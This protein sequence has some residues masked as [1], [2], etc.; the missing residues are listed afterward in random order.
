MLEDIG[1][2]CKEFWEENLVTSKFLDR[3]LLMCEDNV[4]SSRYS[5]TQSMQLLSIQKNVTQ[6]WT[7]TKSETAAMFKNSDSRMMK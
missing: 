1:E 2:I 7:Q 3:V 6:S 4:K 5:N